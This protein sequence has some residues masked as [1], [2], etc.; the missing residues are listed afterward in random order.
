MKSSRNII[1]SLKGSIRDM[2]GFVAVSAMLFGAAVGP[3]EAQSTSSNGTAATAAIPTAPGT[4]SGNT[5]AAGGQVRTS[6]AVAGDFVAAGGR[7]LVDQP[8]RGD[9]TLAGGSVDVSAPVGDDVRAAGGDVSINSTV[10]GEL[11]AS[12]GNITL[13][14]NSRIA[15]AASLFAG[16]VVISGKVAGPLSVRAQTVV[17]DGELNGD[18]RLVADHIKLGPAAKIGGALSY[19]SATELERADGAVIAGV[20]TREGGTRA[21]QRSEGG[22]EGPG[23]MQS[24]GPSWQAWLVIFLALL[25]CSAAFLFLFPTFIVNAAEFIKQTPSISLGIGFSTLLAVPLLATV[26]F[27]T[28]LGIPLAIAVMALYPALM[29]LGFVVGVGYIARIVMT[30]TFK[31][32]THSFGAMLGYFAMALLLTLLIAQI[33]FVGFW[34]V[35]ILALVGLGGSVR[36]VYQRSR[37]RPESLRS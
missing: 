27:T 12:A 8:V 18:A 36:S 33:P 35:I 20:I 13:T 3:A 10:G 23:E 37:I 16:N 19:T 21:Q 29:L 34:V 30:R 7:V 6:L 14:R 5:Y 2:A 26:L 28:V 11:V 24:H 1:E 22:R 9:A 4:R 15:H 25:A 31:N 32:S 17:I